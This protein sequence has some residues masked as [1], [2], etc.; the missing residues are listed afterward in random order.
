[1]ELAFLFDSLFEQESTER[2]E[3]ETTLFPLFSPVQIEFRFF[4]ALV[5]RLI[6]HAV[7]NDTLDR[8]TASRRRLRFEQQKNAVGTALFCSI[9]VIRL[10]RGS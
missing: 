1:M 3:K 6:L 9:R 7:W 8:L 4:S 2:T 10:I 5:D